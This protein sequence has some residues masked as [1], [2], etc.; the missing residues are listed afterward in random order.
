MHCR[1]L[2]SVVIVSLAVATSAAAQ[3][4]SQSRLTWVTNGSVRAAAVHDQTLFIGGDFTRVAPAQNFLGP[5]FGV[6]RTTGA[7]LA[8]LPWADGAVFAI[9]PDGAGGYFVG[10][11][12]SQIGGIAR[13][14][15]AHVLSD[16]RVD[17]A[18][19]PALEPSFDS[20]GD[21]SPVLEVRALARV[22]GT[23]LVGGAL[24]AGTGATSRD[25]AAAL[26]AITGATDAAFGLPATL[27]AERFLV[28][29]P[30]VFIMGRIQSLSP[31]VNAAAVAAIDVALGETVWSR[32]LG[33]GSGGAIF[34]GV[35]AGGRLIVAGSFGMERHALD[36]RNRQPGS[37]LG[38]GKS[39][40]DTHFDVSVDGCADCVRHHGDRL[41]RVPGRPLHPI[42]CVRTQQSC[43]GGPGLR[44]R[45]PVGTRPTRDGVGFRASLRVVGV[46]GRRISS[47]RRDRA[48]RHCRD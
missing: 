21:V 36:P 2:W 12:F 28:D 1:C 47:C 25:G 13:A 19:V 6:S 20:L 10:G 34:D 48:R 33:G 32:R 38:R 41:H 14:A 15:L 44:R 26:D 4:A 9:E 31:P 43:R 24:R 45:H 22:G 18:F 35:L 23:L 46:R 37:G 42:R 16:G 8:T 17:P 30:R 7:P 40:L 39:E 3:P 5:V 27:R 29:G 11:R